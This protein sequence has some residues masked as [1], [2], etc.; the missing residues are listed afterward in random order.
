MKNNL[1]KIFAIIWG[2]YTSGAQSVLKGEANFE[3]EEEV[4]HCP[5]LLKAVK[6][7]TAGINNKENK[8]FMGC[9]SPRR[10]LL[11]HSLVCSKNYLFI[12]GIGPIFDKEL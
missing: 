5:W 2:Q 12:V 6:K 8:Q 9:S 10:P 4:V 11:F 3:R 1:N 7:T